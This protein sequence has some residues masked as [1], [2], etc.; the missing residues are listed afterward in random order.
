MSYLTCEVSPREGFHWLYRFDRYSRY[1]WVFTCLSI[2]GGADVARGR[3]TAQ[4]RSQNSDAAWT[5]FVDI[6]VPSD[7]WEDIQ[8]TFG[9]EEALYEGMA[10]LMEDGYRVGFSYNRQ[11]DAVICSV[12]C[13]NAESENAGLT[14]NSFAAT[15]PEALATSLYKHCVLTQGHWRKT[16][17]GIARP[18]F[19]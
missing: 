3:G 4:A 6:P 7:A 18:R 19:G 9:T 14:F 13:R 11:N 5:A 1:T 16:I 2:I 12:T 17:E 8:A 10:K 15:W